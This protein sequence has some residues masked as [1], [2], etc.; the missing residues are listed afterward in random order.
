MIEIP[1]FNAVAPSQET[2]SNLKICQFWKKKKKKFKTRN[3]FLKKEHK[4]K[5]CL[6]F[7]KGTEFLS[8]T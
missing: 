4:A 3:H 1:V 2:Q 6:I 5:F 7:N 8:Q